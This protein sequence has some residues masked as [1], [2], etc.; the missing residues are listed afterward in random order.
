MVV[1]RKTYRVLFF[2]VIRL[3]MSSLLSTVEKELKRHLMSR[4]KIHQNIVVAF[5]QDTY[6]KDNIITLQCQ[7]CNMLYAKDIKLLPLII[8]KDHFRLA[9]YPRLAAAVSSRVLAPS[10][11]GF[12]SST[13]SGFQTP[14]SHN[15]N[16]TWFLTNFDIVIFIVLGNS[17]R[18]NIF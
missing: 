4:T 17:L 11:F 10:G 12:Q 1:Y 2:M 9:E 3:G 6:K 7:S 15:G 18:K 14:W 16:H 13:R 8:I 5:I